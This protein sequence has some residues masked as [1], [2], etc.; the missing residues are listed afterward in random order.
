MQ[1]SI[2]VVVILMGGINELRPK[3]MAVCGDGLRAECGLRIVTNV[4]LLLSP[5]SQTFS[6]C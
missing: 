4:G 5:A 1:L 3:Q 2:F 6:T